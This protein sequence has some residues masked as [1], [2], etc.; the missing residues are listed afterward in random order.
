[1]EQPG[2]MARIMAHAP[3]TA[4][5]DAMTDAARKAADKAAR[6]AAKDAKEPLAGNPFATLFG[7]PMF[8]LVANPKWY[9]DKTDKTKQ[10]LRLA[11][12]DFMLGGIATISA[13][14]YLER[15]I[16]TTAAGKR[17]DTVERFSWPKGI[18]IAKEA[19]AQVQGEM[20]K[21]ACLD[22]FDKWRVDVEKG[23]GGK[24]GKITGRVVSTD[25]AID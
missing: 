6:K 17:A 10:S 25:E 24:I 13:S 23:S 5:G 2:D 22:A 11:F 21:N 12:V 3:A 18:V 8:R 15:Q 14:V 16:K 19:K 7:V 1:M 20:F 4:I 9:D